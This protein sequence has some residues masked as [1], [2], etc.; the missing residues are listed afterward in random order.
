MLSIE[1][2]LAVSGV[3]EKIKQN[4]A[5]IAAVSP[6]VGGRAIKGPA[7]KIFKELGQDPSALAVAKC[8]AG[9]ANGLVID[10][11]DAGLQPLSRSSALLLQSPTPS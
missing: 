11:V 10:A 9:F 7:A 3:R 8:Y 5:P 6:I 2:I 1:P 4:S